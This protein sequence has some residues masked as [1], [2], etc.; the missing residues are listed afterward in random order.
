M[1]TANTGN[2]WPNSFSFKLYRQAWAVG[3]L[4]K[5]LWSGG[6]APSWW[7]QQRRAGR[8]VAQRL[9]WLFWSGFPLVS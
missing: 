8:E 6:V 7:K 4:V 1:K 2:N 9:C 5:R 3:C